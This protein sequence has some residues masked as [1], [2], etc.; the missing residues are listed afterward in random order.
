[1]IGFVGGV[2]VVKGGEDAVKIVQ[3]CSGVVV[4]RRS[5][6]CGSLSIRKER[7]CML[8]MM[9]GNDA[10]AASDL[11]ARGDTLVVEP[12]ERME[13]TTGG[14]VLT[15]ES[16]AD[17]QDTVGKVVSVGSGQRLLHAVGQYEDYGIQVGDTVVFD[18]FG[19][20]DVKVNGKPYKVVRYRSVRAKW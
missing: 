15:Q 1:M 19:S 4:R 18:R 9:S 5:T 13:T 11:E 14:V 8:V 17:D 3:C 16:R 10:G 12:L 6:S 7:R 2:G 20:E